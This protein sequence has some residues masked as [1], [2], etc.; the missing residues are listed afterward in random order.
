ME[1]LDAL[2]LQ[3]PCSGSRRMVDNLANEG[4]PI[5]RDRIRNLLHRK[6]L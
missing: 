4:I 5:R 3:D 6:G 1:R 2:Y